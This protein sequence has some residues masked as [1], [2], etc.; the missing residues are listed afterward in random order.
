MFIDSNFDKFMEDQPLYSYSTPLDTVCEMKQEA[1]QD[2]YW[3]AAESKT[4]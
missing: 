4:E 3:K 2:D 1:I